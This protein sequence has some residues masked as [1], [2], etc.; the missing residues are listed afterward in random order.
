MWSQSRKLLI[1]LILLIFNLRNRLINILFWLVLK[2][3]RDFRHLIWVILIC[4]GQNHPF[5]HIIPL[6]RLLRNTRIGLLLLVQGLQ[7]K[8]FH[9]LVCSQGTRSI[10]VFLNLLLKVPSVII[11]TI[12]LKNRWL[13]FQILPKPTFLFR[14]DCILL[15]LI[16]IDPKRRILRWSFISLAHLWKQL[17]IPGWH[18]RFSKRLGS[19]LWLLLLFK[20]LV[21][22]RFWE[23]TFNFS[24]DFTRVIIFG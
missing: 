24:D 21:Y 13:R 1:S 19:L 20:L 12:R 23:F 8:V 6:T 10:L 18:R 7:G 2:L 11:P 22:R 15:N 16:G 14:Q 5:K 17:I 3:I 4:L 9:W